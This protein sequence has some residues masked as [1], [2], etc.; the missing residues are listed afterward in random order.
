MLQ[1]AIIQENLYQYMLMKKI[2]LVIWD[3]MV[4]LP[5]IGF[6]SRDQTSYFFN[7]VLFCIGIISQ[8]VLLVYLRPP[9]EYFI[10]VGP[11][12]IRHRSP[13]ELI[14]FILLVPAFIVT[15]NEY[16]ILLEIY[17]ILYGLFQLLNLRI[18]AKE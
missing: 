14:V 10:R 7:I 13:L 9:A 2:S 5:F 15:F 11:L 6:L 12:I 16:E 4:L 3:L 1:L 8:I 18:E 17:I